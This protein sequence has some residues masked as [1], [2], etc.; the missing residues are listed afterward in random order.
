MGWVKLNTDGVSKAN[1]YAGCGGL[2]R[3]V[4]NEWLGASKKDE[5]NSKEVVTSIQ[6]KEGGSVLGRRFGPTYWT[7]VGA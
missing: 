3:G 5:L 2:I 6:S 4:D 1:A 7:I